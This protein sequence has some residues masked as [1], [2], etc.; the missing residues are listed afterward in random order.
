ME[1][2]KAYKTKSTSRWRQESYV[3]NLMECN[4]LYEIEANINAVAQLE[5]RLEIVEYYIINKRK[6]PI[7]RRVVEVA[8]QHRVCMNFNYVIKVQVA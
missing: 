3:P 6:K 1:S 4:G 2:Q 5:E 8:L 7:S